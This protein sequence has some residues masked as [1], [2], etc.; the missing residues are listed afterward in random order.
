[1]YSPR[2]QAQVLQI[3]Q[4]GSQRT[5]PSRPLLIAA[6]F[7]QPGLSVVAASPDSPE[8]AAVTGI[9]TPS[10][11]YDSIKTLHKDKVVVRAGAP[12]IL[13]RIFS[14]LQS[15]GQIYATAH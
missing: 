4:G 8:A 14:P 9:L 11:I 1:M 10:C 6:C 12:F 13:H 7:A 3:P 5:S 15:L 2:G